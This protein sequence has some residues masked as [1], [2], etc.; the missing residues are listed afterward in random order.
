MSYPSFA[1]GG[2]TDIALEQLERPLLNIATGPRVSD[3]E[4]TSLPTDTTSDHFERP[5]IDT[6]PGPDG[7]DAEYAF[8]P[9]DTK[10]DHPEQPSIDIGL[11]PKEQDDGYA[12][13]PTDEYATAHQAPTAN[14]FYRITL[15]TW[16]PEALALFISAASILAITA[17]LVRYGDKKS[18]EMSYGIT[19]NAIVSILATASRS[20]LIFA[21]SM[22][23]GQLKWCWYHERKCKVEDIQTMVRAKTP[24]ATSHAPECS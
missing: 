17:I 9:T 8:L 6:G 22:C 10:S 15:D 11:V 13:L 7:Q 24:S 2:S 19:L 12:S 20:L 4:Y 16:A 23:I 5:S 1:D 21:V 3:V 18:P 14:W